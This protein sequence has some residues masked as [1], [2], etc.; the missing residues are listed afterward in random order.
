M[1]ISMNCTCICVI[2][3]VCVAYILTNNLHKWREDSLQNIL[4]S[5]KSLILPEHLPVLASKNYTNITVFADLKYSFS[6]VQPG[7]WLSLRPFVKIAPVFEPVAQ[8]ELRLI[9]CKIHRSIESEPMG[10]S[11]FSKNSRQKSHV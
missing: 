11:K 6:V 5:I 10:S 8:P 2:T 4:N 7:T 9:P 3:S 1:C